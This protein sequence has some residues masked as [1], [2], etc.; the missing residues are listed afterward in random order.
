MSRPGIEPGPL[1]R[2]ASALEKSHLDSLSA[3]YSEPLL[4][5]RRNI[6]P[7]HGCPQCMRRHGLDWVWPNSPCIACKQALQALMQVRV[8]QITSGSPLIEDHDQG[9]LYTNLEVPRL[10]CP[11]RGSNPASR[12]GSEHSR[13]EPSR[14]LI[15]WL[16]GTT[17][18]AEAK[19]PAS[20]IYV[21]F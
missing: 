6:Q 12:A 8:I 3:G 19:H 20:T 2:E 17:T 9:H 13:K 15:C 1:A 7:L 21:F 10:T 14:Q 11:G 18:W 16:F 5:L 4:G